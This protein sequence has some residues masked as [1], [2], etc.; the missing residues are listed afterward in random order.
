MKYALNLIIALSFCLNAAAKDKDLAIKKQEGIVGK[1]LL[2]NTPLNCLQF[3]L[4]YEIF[5]W[6]HDSAR[7]E[8]IVLL[9][10]KGMNLNRGYLSIFD[11]KT[12]S[13]RWEMPV[14]TFDIFTCRDRV[15]VTSSAAT[16]CY[17]RA[18]GQLQ[19]RAEEIRIR[20]VDTL[21]EI[22]ISSLGKGLDLKTG[23]IIWTKKLRGDDYLEDY[24]QLNDT[25]IAAFANGLHVF[26][27]L[28]GKGITVPGKT[29]KRDVGAAVAMGIVGGLL[30]GVVGGMLL[31]SVTDKKEVHG[32]SRLLQAGDKCYFTMMNSIGCVDIASKLVLW[33]EA[34]DPQWSSSCSMYL[35]DG[36][37][38]LINDGMVPGEKNE[39]KLS[40]RAYMAVYDQGTGAQLYEEELSRYYGALRDKKLEDDTLTFIYIRTVVKMNIKNRAVALKKRNPD[41]ESYY[42]YFVDTSNTYIARSDARF[43]R[44]NEVYPEV[45]EA[46]VD[47]KHDIILLDKNYDQLMKLNSEALCPKVAGNGTYDLLVKG[48]NSYLL[49]QGQTV[50]ELT[51]KAKGLLVDNKYYYFD[52]EVMNVVELE[53]LLP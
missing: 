20:H 36:K 23:Q 12:N 22:G 30:G 1:D 4:P 15:L 29:E 27:S 3:Q 37:L 33:D 35:Y 41:I 19:W 32:T 40:G 43:K 45:R 5:S 42:H 51:T 38:V 17:N 13:F 53:K 11:M 26:N 46:I 16:L 39:K 8:I 44:F 6:K 18:D 49:S 34:L 7:Q 25:T 31:Y 9:R 21:N 48:K 2:H 47:S 50:G 28:T 14:S 10:D 52:D 24:V